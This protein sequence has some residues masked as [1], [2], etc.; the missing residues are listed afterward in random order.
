MPGRRVGG[1]VERPLLVFL[2]R[3]LR[4]KR[5]DQVERR[6]GGL[7]SGQRSAHRIA[8]V[9]EPVLAVDVGEQPRSEENDGYGSKSGRDNP[10]RPGSPG[11]VCSEA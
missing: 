8:E 11:S 6:H 2:D 7:G 9:G 3:L 4:R 1:R 5:L 10:L